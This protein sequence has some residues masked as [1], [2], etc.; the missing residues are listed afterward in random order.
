MSRPGR[1]LSVIACAAV[2]ACTPT[3]STDFRVEL[4]AGAAFDRTAAIEV[5][6]HSGTC[7]E[8][9]DVV[10][11]H[12]FARDRAGAVPPTLAAGTYAFEAVARD[13]ACSIVAEGC[14]LVALPL[15][16]YIAVG[17]LVGSTLGPP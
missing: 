7:S 12:T 16:E 5:T 11:A 9:R 10:Y 17:A 8:R 15:L 3:R 13:A 6:I 14:E 2:A 1:A 4:P